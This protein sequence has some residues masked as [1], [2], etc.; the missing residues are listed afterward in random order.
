MVKLYFCAS[1]S[2]SPRYIDKKMSSGQSVFLEKMMEFVDAF[3]CISGSRI[4]VIDRVGREELLFRLVK[5]EFSCTQSCMKMLGY[6]LVV[7]VIIALV[8]KLIAHILFFNKYQ[9]KQVNS[10][11]SV[12]TSSVETSSVETSSVETSSETAQVSGTSQPQEVVASAIMSE[13]EIQETEAGERR[14]AISQDLLAVFQDNFPKTIGDLLVE[15]HLS[16]EEFQVFINKLI[17]IKYSGSLSVLPPSLSEKLARFGISRILEFLSMRDTEFLFLCQ[18][19][20]GD[21]LLSYCPFMWLSRFCDECALERHRFL[22]SPVPQVA[23]K[24]RA[25]LSAYWVSRLGFSD[26][27]TTIFSPVFWILA[28][29]ISDSEYVNLVYYASSDKWGQSQE[30]VDALLVRHRQYVRSRSEPSLRNLNLDRELYAKHLLL[31]AKHGFSL[32]GL[33]LLRCLTL[34]QV[35]TLQDLTTGLHGNRLSKWMT[36]FGNAIY[37]KER[38]YAVCLPCDFGRNTSF[39]QEILLLTWSELRARGVGRSDSEFAEYLSRV[40]GR[41]IVISDSTFD[42]AEERKVRKFDLTTG[43]LLLNLEPRVG[44]ASQQLKW[45]NWS[46]SVYPK[47]SYS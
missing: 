21:I 24:S 19:K 40:S 26:E 20:L 34:D 17:D 5:P 23:W 2:F 37:D 25:S 14:T 1:I 39:S 28:E 36:S 9:F 32:P 11:D 30:I 41:P 35:L 3:L 22:L 4:Q 33:R 47:Y 43:E 38:F 42:E 45:T 46:R 10:C 44:L 15:Q 6:L 16:F 29:M 13:E 8:V 12:E 7:P 27:E 18:N 31:F